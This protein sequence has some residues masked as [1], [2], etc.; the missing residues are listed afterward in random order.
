MS[1]RRTVRVIVSGRVQG[2]GY[3]DWTSDRAQRH[4]LH[5]WVRNLSDGTVEAVLAGATGDVDAVLAAMHDGPGF[6]R[7]QKVRIVEEDGESP[8]PGFDILPTA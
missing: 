7:V 2:V 4:S 8:Q 3:R 5:G 6:A 1:K